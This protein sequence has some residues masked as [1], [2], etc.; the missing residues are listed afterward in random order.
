MCLAQRECT[1]TRYSRAAPRM[2]VVAEGATSVG[3][4]LIQAANIRL[5]R[6]ESRPGPADHADSGSR[7]QI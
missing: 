6:K 2:P 4:N 7:L 3:L 1:M 5:I